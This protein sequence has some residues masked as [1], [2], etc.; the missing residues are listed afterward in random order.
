MI[1]DFYNLQFSLCDSFKY[2]LLPRAK[3][4][5]YIEYLSWK[6]EWA[7]CQEI[8]EHDHEDNSKSDYDQLFWTCTVPHIGRN[9]NEHNSLPQQML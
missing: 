3:L 9:K 4:K 5:G 7:L 1:A 8:S 6:S 2:M